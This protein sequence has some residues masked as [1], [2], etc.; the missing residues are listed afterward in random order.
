MAVK[1]KNV[2]FLL[3]SRVKTDLHF[4]VESVLDEYM[5]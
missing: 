1:E 4:T 5:D 2:E 3:R